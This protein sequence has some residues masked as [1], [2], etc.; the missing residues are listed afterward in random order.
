LS[1]SGPAYTWAGEETTG[2]DPL[3]APQ[4]TVAGKVHDLRLVHLDLA[5]GETG[6][7]T[8]TVACPLTSYV[9]FEIRDNEGN[10]LAYT[11][12]IPA[13]N[14]VLAVP[15]LPA[16]DYVIDVGYLVAAV[17]VYS[18]SASLT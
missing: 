14:L 9:F 8:A 16:G 10:Q 1:K 12:G 18:A 13:E 6:T 3:I 4:I 15:D 5:A 2:A 17:A 7:L 11:E